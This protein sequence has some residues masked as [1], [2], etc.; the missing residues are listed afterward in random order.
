MKQYLIL[1]SGIG[2]VRT[3]KEIIESTIKMVGLDPNDFV[4]VGL[5]TST[6]LCIDTV[7]H[8]KE[9]NKLAIAMI[10]SHLTVM[11]ADSIK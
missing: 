9:E 8:S 7:I 10:K 2:E 6:S 4:M 11:K 3:H 5:G 1:I